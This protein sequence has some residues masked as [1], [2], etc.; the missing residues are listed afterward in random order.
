MGEFAGCDDHDLLSLLKQILCKYGPQWTWESSHM[1]Y[2]TVEIA[3]GQGCVFLFE[4]SDK[5]N[6][7]P[8]LVTPMSAKIGAPALLG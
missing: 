6:G 7:R 1:G 2:P 5:L 3:C 4:M 8:F